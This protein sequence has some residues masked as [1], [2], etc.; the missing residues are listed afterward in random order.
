MK[1]VR[2]I[3][4]YWELT[5][6]RSDPRPMLDSH[7]YSY[8]F[9]HDIS[10]YKKYDDIEKWCD[11]LIGHKNWYRLYDKFW[12]TDQELFIQFKLTWYDE[13]K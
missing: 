10:E 11:E 3:L 1:S 7:F 5:N 13:F 9:K 6:G 12:F 2:D 4:L 8:K